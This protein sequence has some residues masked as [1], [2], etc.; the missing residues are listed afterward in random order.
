MLICR[1]TLLHS[2][3]K[4]LFLREDDTIMSTSLRNSEIINMNV[5]LGSKTWSDEVGEVCTFGGGCADT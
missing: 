5:S 1:F 4:V 3:I 2:S